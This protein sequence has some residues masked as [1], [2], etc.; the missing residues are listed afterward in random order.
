MHDLL[1]LL[2]PTRTASV[3]AV[4]ASASARSVGR[5]LA[6]GRL[7]QL[8]P[9]WVT[10]PEFAEDWTVRAY[11]ATGYVRGPLSHMS[12][13]AV[14]G[15]VDNRVTRLDVTVAGERR[16]RSSRWLR[17]HRS[18][19]PTAVV[20]VRGLPATTLARSLIDTWGDAHRA[21]AMRA[22]TRSPGPPASGPPV[23]D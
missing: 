22:S 9:G 7:V 6:T 23:S 10:T 11:A 12:A 4:S 19:I 3:A 17:V 16:L 18:R 14:H 2:G 13:L 20:R 8:H 21:R 1:P 5:W 15:V